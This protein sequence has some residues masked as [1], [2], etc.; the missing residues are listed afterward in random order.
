MWH[1]GDGWGWWMAF[2]WVWMAA[3]WGLILWAVFA[4]IS[5]LGRERRP[6]RQDDATAL[7]IA[8]RRFARGEITAEEFRAMRRT[9][10]QRDDPGAK[11]A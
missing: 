10:E 9:L 4:L 8:E 1:M 6:R 3:F 7:E 5:R 2:G 11:G